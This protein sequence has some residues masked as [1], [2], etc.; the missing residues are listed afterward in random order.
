MEYPLPLLLFSPN[1]GWEPITDTIFIVEIRPSSA[2]KTIGKKKY[3]YDN[4]TFISKFLTNQLTF[5][6]VQAFRNFNFGLEVRTDSKL[7]NEW[8]HKDI[9]NSVQE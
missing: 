6:K 4:L 7:Y 9:H 5:V 1:E 8:H 3:I 2:I